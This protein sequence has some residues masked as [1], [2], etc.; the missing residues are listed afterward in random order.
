MTP[1]MALRD[2]RT[3]GTGIR[4]ERDLAADME[5]KKE[6]DQLLGE[7]AG[8]SSPTICEDDRHH[9]LSMMALPFISSC[10]SQNPETIR[11]E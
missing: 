7:R 6:H 11:G 5:C 9:T 8:N 10:F 1:N 3:R 2:T 4:E